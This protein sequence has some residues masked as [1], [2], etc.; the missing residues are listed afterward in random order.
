MHN[1]LALPSRTD[2]RQLHGRGDV[3]PGELLSIEIRS[4]ISG[5]PIRARL[6]P[7]LWRD[8]PRTFPATAARAETI[9]SP[10]LPS[11]DGC[12]LAPRPFLRRAILARRQRRG[13][14]ER[15]YEAAPHVD[16]P[17]LGRPVSPGGKRLVGGR[18]ALLAGRASSIVRAALRPSSQPAAVPSPSR[19]GPCPPGRE[20]CSPSG[21]PCSDRS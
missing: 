10:E 13:V 20:A 7:G 8:R 11:N 6:E 15:L 14:A 2:S 9:S 19:S 5:Y 16:R 18:R 21:A 4:Q 17:F 3:T 12:D 1:V